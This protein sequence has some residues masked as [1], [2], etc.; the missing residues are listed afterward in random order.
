MRNNSYDN[1]E[2][3]L[4]D[5]VVV[6]QQD[7][8]IINGG[9]K[10]EGQAH[11][12][13]V[14]FTLYTTTFGIIVA[15]HFLFLHQLKRKRCRR[16]VVTSYRSIIIHKKFHQALLAILSHPPITSV[17]A[18]SSYA[19][20]QHSRE[21]EGGD[22]N[23]VDIE[24]GYNG[25]VGERRWSHIPESSCLSILLS[26]TGLLPWATVRW[27]FHKIWVMKKLL[28][29]G[30]L[31][32]LPLMTYIS[33][34]LWE[35]R[36]LEEIYDNCHDGLS[37]R[38]G[39]NCNLGIL[40]DEKNVHLNSVHES[41]HREHDSTLQY[42]RVLIVLGFVAICV[43]LTITHL[44]IVQFTNVGNR[45]NIV[46]KLLD[47][48]YCTLTSLAAALLII[49]V[50]HFPYTPIS[51]LPLLDTSVIGFGT[52][53]LGFFLNFGFLALLSFR[54]CGISGLLYGSISGLLWINGYTTFLAT[55]YWNNWLLG[56]LTLSCLLSI[57]HEQN[58]RDDGRRRGQSSSRR[59]GDID[60][61]PFIDS[62]AWDQ[63]GRLGYDVET[64]QTFVTL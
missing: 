8:I 29:M 15:I 59:D 63:C 33:H 44:L 60:W 17:L 3:K 35:C 11:P 16:D 24:M 21:G 61:L 58:Q 42:Y 25:A 22:D 19:Y 28:C 46:E 41:S 10:Q 27:L 7:E 9:D 55:R 57:K 48:E 26:C 43:H 50:D 5:R 47:K 49:Y 2:G 30:S 39:T 62:V 23:A 53:S 31:S 4:L 56:C 51:A 32:G 38:H 6:V 13:G 40:D 12:V 45:Q 37:E 52:S 20:V 18:E 64:I 54:N 1:I 36:L 34:V 14:A